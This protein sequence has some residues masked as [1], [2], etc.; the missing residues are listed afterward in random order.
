M[1][2][3]VESWVTETDFWLALNFAT[4]L[5]KYGM[6]SGF[7]SSRTM[8]VRPLEE[9]H[10]ATRTGP[11]TAAAPPS[12]SAFIIDLRVRRVRPPETGSRPRCRERQPGGSGPTADH[13]LAA[14]G[15]SYDPWA[16]PMGEPAFV[17]TEGRRTPNRRAPFR[18][19]NVYG[20]VSM[21]V[22]PPV[23]CVKT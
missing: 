7:V 16:A 10:P 21:K 22:D 4:R 6:T 20:N 1:R 3:E 18:P 23:R 5:S 19:P 13:C 15:T 2:L 11:A 17:A 14:R 12:P 8:L 9:E